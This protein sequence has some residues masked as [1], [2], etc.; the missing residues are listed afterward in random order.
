MG[1]SSSQMW[2]RSVREVCR[3]PQGPDF[4]SSS[5]LSCE[6]CAEREYEKGTALEKERADAAATATAVVTEAV[7]D[8]AAL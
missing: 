1:S 5:P 3:S 4:S 6:L 2:P 7:A 8:K